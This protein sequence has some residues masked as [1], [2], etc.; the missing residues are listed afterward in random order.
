MEAQ[1]HGRAAATLVDLG[2]VERRGRV[3]AALDDALRDGHVTLS[4]LHAHLDRLR[5]RGC[6]GA[7]VLRDLLDDPELTHRPPDSVFERKLIPQ[8]ARMNVPQPVR[9]HAAY[10]GEGFMGSIDF[11]W[12]QVMLGLEADSWE[13][14]SKRGDWIHDRRRRN[15]MTSV[16]WHILHGTWADA[17]NPERLAR[18]IAG[19]FARSTT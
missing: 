4:A 19:F 17:E 15:R 8:L 12:P 14:H 1:A 9:Q 18:Y 7:G 13:H 3:Q 10:D 6:R 16:G 2:A 11:A 5:G